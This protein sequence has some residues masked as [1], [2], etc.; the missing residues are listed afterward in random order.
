ML[1]K[2]ENQGQKNF[3]SPLLIEFIDRTH[4][5]VLLADKIDWTVFV[6]FIV[7]KK[8]AISNVRLVRSMEDCD[9]CN[10]EAVRLIKAMPK[11]IPAIHKGK[12]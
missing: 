2:S 4:E 7:S 9:A 6:R 1:G 12:R 11:W 5:L 10:K 8:G 3:F